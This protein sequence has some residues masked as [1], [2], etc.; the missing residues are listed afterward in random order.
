MLLT[1]NYSFFYFSNSEVE[2]F[3]FVVLANSGP[4]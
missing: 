4:D 1:A 3:G 2:L